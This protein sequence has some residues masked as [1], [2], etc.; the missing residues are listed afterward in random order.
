MHAFRALAAMKG[1]R[2]TAFDIFGRT[3]ERR[4]ERALIQEYDELIGELIAGLNSDN[5]AL[6]VSLA[7]L[8]EAIRGYGHVKSAN[9]TKTRT[10][11]RRLLATWRAPSARRQAAE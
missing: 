2:G 11:W 7:S 4:E 9:L 10:E 8:P 3:P 6:A 1:L 5:H